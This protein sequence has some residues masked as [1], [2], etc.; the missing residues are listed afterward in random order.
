M[1][2]NG[3]VAIVTGAGSGFGAGIARA[4]AREGA[5]VACVD[6]DADAAACIATETGGL[7]C[8]ADV[9]SGADVDRMAAAVEA[10]LGPVDILVNNAGVTH[11]PAPLDEVSEEARRACA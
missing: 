8:Q 10:D 7:A 9:S 1:R 11:L 6:I 5:Q 2:L 4:F 3:K